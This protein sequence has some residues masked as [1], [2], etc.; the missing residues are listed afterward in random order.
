LRCVVLRCI[1]LRCAG[2]WRQPE[3]RGCMKGF[4]FGVCGM[5]P[6]W[7]AHRSHCSPQDE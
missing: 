7:H 6:A 2:G 3:K 1:A 5:P 4:A